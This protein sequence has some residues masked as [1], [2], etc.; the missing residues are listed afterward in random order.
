[1]L[2]PEIH[3]RKHL[4]TTYPSIYAKTFFVLS[5]S[6]YRIYECF[7][8]LLLNPLKQHCP[9]KPVQ[10]CCRA[11]GFRPKRSAGLLPAE[12]Y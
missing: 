8:L 9:Y 1:M 5:E 10:P 12:H 2:I 6:F 11:T 3:L 7:V 4:R